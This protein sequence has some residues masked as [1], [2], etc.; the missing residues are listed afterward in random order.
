MLRHRYENQPVNVFTK[1]IPF[2]SENHMKRI[3]T[4]WRWNAK[5][6]R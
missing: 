4:P 3:N 1:T 6:L 5:F 2:Y